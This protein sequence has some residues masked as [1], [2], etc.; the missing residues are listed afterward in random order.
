MM[1]PLVLLSMAYF[2]VRPNT[3][4]V[5]EK[6]LDRA[7]IE[8][9]LTHLTMPQEMKIT[10]NPVLRQTCDKLHDDFV[11]KYNTEP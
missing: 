3:P 6:A 2:V 7:A 11:A 10:R 9:C 8:Y 4:P 5:D 1:G